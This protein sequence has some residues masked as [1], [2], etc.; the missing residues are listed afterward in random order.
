M[1]FVPVHFATSSAMQGLPVGKLSIPN[2]S[3]PTFKQWQQKHHAGSETH[4]AF[5]SLR[6]QYKCRSVPP[7]YRLLPSCDDLSDRAWRS[8]AS[9]VPEYDELSSYVQSRGSTRTG[10]RV[11]A[12]QLPALWRYALQSLRP[13]LAPLVGV[14]RPEPRANLPAAVPGP[15]RSQNPV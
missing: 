2:G 3:T 7:L 4:A 14:K 11:F 8:N 12:R 15:Q 9:A 5:L 13:H 6:E 1:L 10:S